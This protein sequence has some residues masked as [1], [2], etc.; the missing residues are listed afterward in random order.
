MDLILIRTEYR[1]DGIFGELRDWNGNIVAKTLE[2]SYPLDGE[3][4]YYPKIP[5]GTYKCVRGEHRLMGMAHQFE[6][7]EITNVPGHTDILFHQGNFNSDSEGC[8]LLGKSVIRS[9]SNKQM[10]TDSHT[11]FEEFMALEAAIDQFTLTVQ[12]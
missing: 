4:G 12:G 2:H 3:G 7:F 6:T 1:P 5:V 9:S 11:T 10:I 8:V